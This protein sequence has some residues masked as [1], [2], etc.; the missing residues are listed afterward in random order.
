M[1]TQDAQNAIDLMKQTEAA[2]V[3]EINNLEK[4]VN[5]KNQVSI[6]ISSLLKHT[7]F[8][9]NKVCQYGILRASFQ[10]VSTYFT[11]LFS[12]N[13]VPKTMNY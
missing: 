8:F 2:H 11:S 7:L 3:K 12:F 13:Y 10:V 6:S 9:P 5:D 1:F 4:V